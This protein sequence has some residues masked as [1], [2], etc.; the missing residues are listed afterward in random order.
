MVCSLA[1]FGLGPHLGCLAAATRTISR[2][3]AR[4]TPTSGGGCKAGMPFSAAGRES[5][6]ATMH[7]YMDA[8]VADP[9]IMPR[10]SDTQKGSR[11]P[12]SKSSWR[13]QRGGPMLTANRGP[14]VDDLR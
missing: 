14:D 5:G 3:T 9:P 10:P 4:G 2:P 8:L 1:G 6:S 7:P 13:E 11:R 12:Y